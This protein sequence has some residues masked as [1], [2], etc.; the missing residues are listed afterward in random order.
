MKESLPAVVPFSTRS[1]KGLQPE[2]ERQ[3][4]RMSKSGDPR[5]YEPLV[6]AY[7]GPGLRLA[8]GMLGSVDEASWSLRTRRTREPRGYPEEERVV[9]EK[10]SHESLMRYLAG[11][12]AP[13][14]RARID[15]AVAE[16][17]ELQRDLVIYRTMK[18]DLQAMTFGLAND[19]SVWGAVHRRITRPLGWILL[20]VGF[21]TWIV[22]G[23]YLYIVSAID[24]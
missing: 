11:E 23:S 1:E 5:S 12:A 4:V 9:T 13:E 8:V 24:A 20:S 14:E 10:M 22:Y 2:V 6:R 18:S 15:A 16:S 7:E 17:T 3:V 21:L 19:H